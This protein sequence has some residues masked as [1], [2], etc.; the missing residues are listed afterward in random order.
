[1]NEQYNQGTIMVVDD[2]P[3][4]LEVL[5]DMLEARGYRVL[6]FPSGPMALRAASK[7][8]PD[9]ILLDITMPEM[10]GYEVARHL[11][12]DERLREIPILFISAL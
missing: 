12:E 7:N 5:R 2:L 1:M 3:E 4:N 8:P 9:L 6:L 10:D 11:K